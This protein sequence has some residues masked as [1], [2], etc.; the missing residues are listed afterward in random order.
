MRNM[1]E[2]VVHVNKRVS[3]VAAH[4]RPGRIRS[5]TYL[6][7]LMQHN[8]TIVNIDCLFGTVGRAGIS[9][10]QGRAGRHHHLADLHAHLTRRQVTWIDIGRRPVE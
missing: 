2:N 4:H 6:L 3:S 5:A 1:T 9:Q 8:K 10:I 7:L